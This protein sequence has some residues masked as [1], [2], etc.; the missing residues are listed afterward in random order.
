MKWEVLAVPK[1]SADDPTTIIVDA[2]NWMGA[3]ELMLKQL[4]KK[5]KKP[6]IISCQV[7]EDLSV[8]ITEFSTRS[9]FHIRP[10]DGPPDLPPVP[11]AEGASFLES[12]RSKP[13][14]AAVIEHAETAPA[15]EPAAQEVQ[16]FI[17]EGKDTP[18][19][20]PAM[21]DHSVFYNKDEN[22][23]RESAIV[24]RER[25][26]K[27]APDVTKDKVTE[28]IQHYFE[29]LR[30]EIGKISGDRQINLAVY[31]HEFTGKPERLALTAISWQEWKNPEPIIVYP[32][33]EAAR[34]PS[35]SSQGF[36]YAPT[37]PQ[38]VSDVPP[39][40]AQPSG[41][42]PTAGPAPAQAT[43]APSSAPQVSPAQAKIPD[44]FSVDVQV[45]SG[46]KAAPPKAA[47]PR[48]AP[49]RAAPPQAAPEPVIEEF[50]ADRVLSEVFE[51][52]QDMF[53]LQTQDDC[54]EFVIDL[55]MKKIPVEGG[56]IFLADI[57]TRDMLFAAVRGPS[58]QNLKG[59]VLDM[60]KGIV[61]FT[62]REGAAIAISDVSK[63][64]R[65][66]SDFDQSGAFKT[67]SVLCAPIQYEGRTFGAIE[68]LNK[69]GSDMFTQGEINVVTYLASQ[70]AEYI[71]TSL[72][73][74]EPDFL[75]EE[76]QTKELLKKAKKASPAKSGRPKAKKKGRGRKK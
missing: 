43:S 64:P 68:L 12:K 16:S 13:K 49:P 20:P 62:A 31:D 5:D 10:A 55:S 76:S 30:R 25:L 3:L 14:I 38:Q 4:G 23:D 59:R 69:I 36:E 32:K 44:R 61:G 8:R 74:G 54:A 24:Y 70:L 6:K 46:P 17:Q 51:E 58:A 28:L 57:N 63:D 66:C 45:E 18:P 48:A 60:R 72:P 9:T 52:L 71:A 39:P 27:V 26:I 50:D 35:P 53:L 67:K 22:P 21:T 47:P 65:F 42:P 11:E 34:Q 73:S 15:A 56:T 37:N 33:E 41:P 75:E 1:S 29:T 40:Q 7:Q 2:D 19:V